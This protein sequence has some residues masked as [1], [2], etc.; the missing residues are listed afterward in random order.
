MK[1][2]Y[3]QEKI[4]N[5][6]NRTYPMSLKI[7]D[8][9]INV[10]PSGYLIQLTKWYPWVSRYIQ[11][12]Y[13]NA[14]SCYYPNWISMYIHVYPC[15]YPYYPDV[16]SCLIIPY[17]YLHVSINI[18]TVY[19]VMLSYHIHIDIQK[20]YLDI[21]IDMLSVFFY[22]LLCFPFDYPLTPPMSGGVGGVGCNDPDGPGAAPPPR[23]SE[24]GSAGPGTGG[25]IKTS[26]LP[27]WWAGSMC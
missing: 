27:R 16:L 1:L 23:W 26:C 18:Q 20:H 5:W 12:L 11:V 25:G 7:L 17:C 24:T 3:T 8:I 19:P 10:Y 9:S 15:L 2:R 22:I 14:L 21:S 13:P 4:S 6:D